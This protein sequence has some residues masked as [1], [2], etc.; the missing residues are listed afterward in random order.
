LRK[1]RK[2]RQ[3]RRIQRARAL[4]LVGEVMRLALRRQ[5]HAD[6]QPLYRRRL[7]QSIGGIGVPRRASRLRP[8]EDVNDLPPGAGD[9][10]GWCQQTRR[11]T[12]AYAYLRPT[13][14]PPKVQLVTHALV[15]RVRFDGK[16]RELRGVG[17]NMQDHYVARVSYPLV[18]VQTANERS[19]GLLLAGEVMR[20][21]FTGKGM[22]TYS[23]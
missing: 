11:A 14:K 10:I 12:S 18:G 5:G 19:R 6:L 23:P 3:L 22:L 4:P 17:K 15:H 20:W 2:F 9:S 7:G 16:L 13:L 8:R 21:L 1:I